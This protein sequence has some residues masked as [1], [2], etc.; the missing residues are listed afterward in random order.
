MEETTR[1]DPEDPFAARVCIR[2]QTKR[3]GDCTRADLEWL[4]TVAGRAEAA[5]R[6]VAA[7]YAEC[8]AVMERD[9]LTR[10]AQLP[11]DLRA[12]TE[13]AREHAARM[14]RNADRAW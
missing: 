1:R 10:G 12:R 3:F 5:C 13:H 9:G 11:A 6:G 7:L 2:G 8:K 4:T 14:K